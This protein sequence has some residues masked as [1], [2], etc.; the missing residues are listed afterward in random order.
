MRVQWSSLLSLGAAAVLSLSTC[1]LHADESESTRWALIFAPGEYQALPDSVVHE[2]GAERLR[3]QLLRSGFQSEHISLLTGSADSTQRRATAS[4]FRSHLRETVN[5]SGPDDV[6]LVAVLSYGVGSGKSD[7]IVTANTSSAELTALQA[8]RSGN[9][10]DSIVSIQEIAEVMQTSATASQL[11]LVDG[12]VGESDPQSVPGSSQFANGELQLLSGQYVVVNRHSGTRRGVTE[13]NASICDGL[14]EFAD[15]DSSQTISRDELV[16]HIQRYARSMKLQPEPVVK[17][18]IVADFNLATAGSLEGSGAFT[19]DLRDQMARTLMQSAR[20]L[21]LIVQSPDDARDVLKRAIAYRPSDEL[22][23]EISSML[24]T[25]LAAEGNFEKAWREA[26]A[27][28]QPLLVQATGKFSI[29]ASGKPV[30]TVKPGELVLFTL[31]Q[32]VTP[33]IFL[34]PKKRYVVKYENGAVA[35]EELDTPSGWSRLSD[36]QVG[37]TDEQAEPSTETLVSILRQLNGQRPPGN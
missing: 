23:A 28:N 17:G 12:A 9:V 22:K 5:A 4:N 6:L 1:S 29:E 14:T 34:H 33:D 3:Q 11:L 37:R 13:F 16:E 18:N 7:F 36:I 15:G 25:L 8:S 24:L 31:R 27:L 26:E 10:A 35:F 20:H 32:D 30:G 2:R 19:R 21:L